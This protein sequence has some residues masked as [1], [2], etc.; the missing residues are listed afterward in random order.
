MAASDPKG[1]NRSD[2]LRWLE[3]HGDLLFRFAARRVRDRTVAEDLVQDTLLAAIQAAAALKVVAN[4]RAW[5]IGI[6]RHKLLDYFRR[7]AREQG[8]W[9][10]SIETTDGDGAF[11]ASGEWRAPPR[12]WDTPDRAVERAELRTAFELCI[13]DLP[14]SWRAPFVLREVDGVESGALAESLGMT[15]NH[16]W[17]MLSRARQRMRLCIEHYFGGM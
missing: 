1:P 16:V 5:L 14:L 12:D 3:D 11:A 7:R 8:I 13:D 4:E 15:K 2:A 6:L 17:V 9:D 10:T